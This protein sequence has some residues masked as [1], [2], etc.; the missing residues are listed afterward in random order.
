MQAK[1]EKRNDKK[2]KGK[3]KNKVMIA[4]KEAKKNKIKHTPT[5]RTAPHGEVIFVLKMVKNTG[6][7]SVL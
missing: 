5:R 2:K 6:I 7:Y 3:I 1:K 4:R